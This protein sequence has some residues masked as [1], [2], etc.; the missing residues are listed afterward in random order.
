M[1]DYPKTMIEFEQRFITKDA[2]GLSLIPAIKESV[3]PQSEVRT[4][5]WEGYGQLA[6]S[7]YKHTMISKTADVVDNLL[8]LVNLTVSLLK[9]WLQGTH[10]G[11]PQP[12]YL[13]YYFD[14]FVFR[15]FF[16]AI[17]W[18]IILSAPLTGHEYCPG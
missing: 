17:A 3:Q 6:S 10:Q 8:P 11:A 9:R 14:E 13:N 7:G 5:G 16:L 15:F 4:D 12:S 1:D 18:L 2:S